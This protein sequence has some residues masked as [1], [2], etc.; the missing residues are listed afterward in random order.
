MAAL[1]VVPNEM[2]DNVFLDYQLKYKDDPFVLF[3]LEVIKE[4]SEENIMMN[5][6]KENSK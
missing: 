6:E 2:N 3:L 1:E 4:L 5:N